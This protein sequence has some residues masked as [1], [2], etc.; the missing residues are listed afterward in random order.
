M[1]EG[2]G[3]HHDEDEDDPKPET[4]ESTTA[5]VTDQTVNDEVSSSMPCAYPAVPL[6]G[7]DVAWRRHPKC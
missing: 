7:R 3:T 5:D 4:G 2:D 6:V 1:S